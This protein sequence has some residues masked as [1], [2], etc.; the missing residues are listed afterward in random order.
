MTNVR[1]V[2]CKN[3]PYLFLI[4]CSNRGRPNVA[5]YHG[6]T[7]S[8][9]RPMRICGDGA[10]EDAMMCAAQQGSRRCVYVGMIA[11]KLCFMIHLPSILL[12]F[13]KSADSDRFYQKVII[14]LA[15]DIRRRCKASSKL[16][17]PIFFIRW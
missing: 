12:P 6:G 16:P 5:R 15:L 8:A 3:Y 2:V 17:H 13:L 11:F 1:I 4:D 14:I 7:C 9:L 10:F